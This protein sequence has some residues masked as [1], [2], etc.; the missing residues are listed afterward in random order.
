MEGKVEIGKE[1]KATG[2]KSRKRHNPN[3]CPHGE[4]KV[5]QLYMTVKLCFGP[6]DENKQT[7]K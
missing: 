6:D 4:T 3:P 1:E 5:T 2:Q 7:N